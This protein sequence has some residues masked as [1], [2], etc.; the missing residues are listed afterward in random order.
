MFEQQNYR[1]YFTLYGYFLPMVSIIFYEYWI[2]RERLISG[3]YVFGTFLFLLHVFLHNL[4][5]L[6]VCLLSWSTLPSI[7]RHNVYP[8]G[9]QSH[10]DDK[11]I[12]I[13]DFCCVQWIQDIWYR[14]SERKESLQ[15][16]VL[17]FSDNFLPPLLLT[18]QWCLHIKREGVVY[19]TLAETKVGL[20]ITGWCI[21]YTYETLHL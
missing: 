17:S 7:L 1:R 16:T 8:Q 21:L 5:S 14:G 11:A 18:L 10:T 12:Y 6:D 20:L 2:E 13:R 3:M 4:I 9:F 19:V 15:R